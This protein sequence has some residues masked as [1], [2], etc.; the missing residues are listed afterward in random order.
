M[1]SQHS[2]KSPSQR[3]LAFSPLQYCQSG[4]GC[5]AWHHPL[6]LRDGDL[7][8]LRAGHSLPEA[9]AVRHFAEPL[10][11]RGARQVEEAV[12]QVAVRPSSRQGVRPKRNTSRGL[13]VGGNQRDGRHWD[14]SLF[15]RR[16]VFLVRSG[17]VRTRYNFGDRPGCS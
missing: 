7:A 9:E 12:A 8:R 1:Q 15:K 6:L 17:P 11:D 3:P 14:G 5:A 2:P 4:V 13:S 16:V 10:R